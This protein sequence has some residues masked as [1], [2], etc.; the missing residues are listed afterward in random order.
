MTLKQMS[1]D[2]VKVGDEVEIE[3]KYV[4]AYFHFGGPVTD[5]VNGMIQIGAIGHYRQVVKVS[6]DR[7]ALKVWV[8]QP[9]PPAR[10]GAVVKYYEPTLLR[11]RAAFLRERGD[12]LDATSGDV[13]KIDRLDWTVLFDPAKDA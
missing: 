1:F 3:E 4:D 2:D 13:V 11:Y 12:W 8:K 7:Q 5:V 10:P 9:D 6:A